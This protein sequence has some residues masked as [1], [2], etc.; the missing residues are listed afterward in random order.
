MDRDWRISNYLMMN[1]REVPHGVER[2][3]QIV[4]NSECEKPCL[5]DKEIVF[6]FQ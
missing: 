5:Y 4:K 2:L 3:T 1:N 6:F